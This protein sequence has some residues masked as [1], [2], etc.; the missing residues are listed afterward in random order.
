MDLVDRDGSHLPSFFRI[1]TILLVSSEAV[2]WVEELTRLEDF[3]FPSHFR[4][5][6]V[7]LP[8]LHL[9]EH[10]YHESTLRSN[11]ASAGC[12]GA[13]ILSTSVVITMNTHLSSMDRPWVSNKT[14]QD[15]LIYV[16]YAYPIILLVLFLTATTAHA[17]LTASKDEV[18]QAKPDQTGPGGKP[19]P[20]TTSPGAKEKTKKVIEFSPSRKLCFTW[21][22]VLAILTFLG[23]AII[24]I[25]H[26]LTDKKNNWWC[27][28]S[29]VVRDI[30]CTPSILLILKFWA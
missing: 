27:G 2:P 19:L 7:H 3:L 14:A 8:H 4:H 22:S 29:V 16:H 28:E 20:R 9:H 18:G 6:H 26:A 25:V 23:D 5:D 21:I 1:V 12:L 13:S 17:V 10:T 15:I 30:G 24:A 11:T